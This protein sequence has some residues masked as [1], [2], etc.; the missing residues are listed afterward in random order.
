[1]VIAMSWSLSVLSADGSSGCGPGWYLFKENSILSSILR[2]TTNGILF[3]VTTLGMTFGTSNCSKHSLV[4]TE[5][6]S[7]KFATENYFEILAEATK[8]QGEFITSYAVTIGC[9]K[10][11]IDTFGKELKNSY[12]NLYLLNKQNPEELLRQ[13]YKVILNNKELVYSCSL[14]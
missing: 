3:P 11:S 12:Q 5:Q 10:E 2:V 8:G 1:M 4:Q 7:L 13:T 14:S 6:E 9:K